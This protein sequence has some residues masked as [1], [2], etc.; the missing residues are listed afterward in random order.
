MIYT[1]FKDLDDLIIQSTEYAKSLEGM[2]VIPYEK[3]S[4]LI[5]RLIRACAHYALFADEF[6]LKTQIA[7]LKESLEMFIK[8][9]NALMDT[10]SIDMYGNSENKSVGILYWQRMKEEKR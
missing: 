6:Y 10:Q 2:M 1:Y 9:Y 7:V 5:F 8:K 4:V 3:L